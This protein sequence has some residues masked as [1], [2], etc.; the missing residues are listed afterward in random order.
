MPEIGRQDTILSHWSVMDFLIR[1][2]LRQEFKTGK[3]HKY[4]NTNYAVL[5]CLIEK[6]SGMSYSDFLKKEIFIL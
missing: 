3:R 1:K 4:C 6:I 5:A 2:K